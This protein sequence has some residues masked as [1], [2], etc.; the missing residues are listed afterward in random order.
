MN[1]KGKAALVTG[2]A[3]RV[4][5]VI[6]TALAK[7]GANIAVHYNT[8]AA[9]AEATAKELR[10][11]GVEAMTVKAELSSE[12]EVAAMIGAVAAKF[13]RLDVL[14]NNAAVFYRTPIESV[15]EAQWDHTIDSNLKGAF[16]CSVHA[17]R[18]ML[19]QPEGGVIVSIADWAGLRPYNGYLPYC[20]SKAG[21]ITMTQGLARSLAPKVRVNAIGPGPILVPTDLPEEEA[22]EIMEKTPLKRHGSP[23]DIAGAVAFLAESDFVTGVFL[24][25]DGGRL[26]A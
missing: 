4:G 6:A 20:I 10:A 16:L 13:G 25:V 1:L 17:G 23:E 22:K 18:R 9:D 2:S 26:V 3:K 19:A 7:R 15:T 21:V 11:L 8:S 12:S 24:P 5:K 14:V